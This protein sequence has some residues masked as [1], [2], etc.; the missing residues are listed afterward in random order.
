M[1]H[2]FETH[3]N[4]GAVIFVDSLCHF[5]PNAI[6]TSAKMSKKDE[7]FLTPATKKLRFRGDLSFYHF[8]NHV[9]D[10]FDDADRRKF[11]SNEANGEDLHKKG[12]LFFMCF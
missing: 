11:K 1:V 5:E 6:E 3:S 12:T 8:D 4:P 9:E 2:V 10:A 7:D